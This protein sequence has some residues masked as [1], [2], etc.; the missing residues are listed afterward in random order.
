MS[1]NWGES[2]PV[3][4]WLVVV[5]CVEQDAANVGEI[6]NLAWRRGGSAVRRFGKGSA[7]GETHG[8]PAR[9]QISP[10][11]SP[12][13]LADTRQLRRNWTTCPS[14]RFCGR[15]HRPEFVGAALGSLEI[16]AL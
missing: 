1:A 3:T 2:S 12:L 4:P 5:D 6:S 7:L 14:P 15:L 8:Q 13:A 16:G 10:T 9:L 11:F